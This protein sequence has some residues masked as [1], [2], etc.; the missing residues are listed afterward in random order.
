M[1]KSTLCL[2]VVNHERLRSKYGDNRYYV[3]LD[4]VT[5]AKSMIVKIAETLGL[6]VDADPF[7]QILGKMSE[8]PT[9][10]ILDNV[11]KCWVERWTKS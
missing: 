2:K 5:T 10:L 1:G 9:L 6:G 3:R 7:G 4:E 8:R 11:E